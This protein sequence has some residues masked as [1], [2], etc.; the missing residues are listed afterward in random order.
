MASTGRNTRAAARALATGATLSTPS[1]PKPSL[2]RKKSLKDND[3]P[4]APAKKK[5]TTFKPGTDAVSD[6]ENV[7]SAS[8]P[9]AISVTSGPAPKADVIPATLTFDFAEAK[10]HLINADARFEK[11]FSKLKCRPYQELDAVEPFRT[12]ASSIL[13]QQISWKA[14]RSIK[15]KFVRLFDPSLP[16]ACPAPGDKQIDFFPSPHAVAAANLN[17]LRSAGLSARKAEYIMDLATRFSDG[18]LSAKKLAEG[19]DE[20]VYDMLIQV[21][22]IGP[23]TVEM[24]SIFSLRRPNILP[25]GD[26]GVQKGLLRWV[27]A[28]HSPKDAAHLK[29]APER[30]PGNTE[31]D[32]Q[33]V[34]ASSND[35]GLETPVA[36]PAKEANL[37]EDADGTSILPTPKASTNPP[38]TP[39]KRKTKA[40]VIPPTPFTPSVFIGRAEAPAAPISLPDGLTVSGLKAR[41]AGKKTK[42]ARDE[43]VVAL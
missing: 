10:S 34:G 7:S 22:G 11:L 36:S 6:E 13:G 30:L 17:N 15:H 26:L 27:L 20:E 39:K 24:F 19:T 21:K 23:W 31:E 25:C 37:D 3:E 4:A 12:L 18:R 42:Y 9:E 35:S 29:I 38:V 2:K 41:L 33:G 43:S 16:E 14:A 40:A 28:S 5:S 32:E 8:A 1:T